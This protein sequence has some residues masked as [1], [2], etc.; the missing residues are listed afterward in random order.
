[1]SLD[2]KQS[3]FAIWASLSAPLIISAWIPGFSPEEYK[4]LTNKEIIA[5]NQDS[6][7]LQCTL[8]SQDGTW[9]VLTKDLANGDRL[10]TVINR[11]STTATQSVSFERIGI[12]SASS[13]HVKD[14]WTGASSLGK[15]EVIAKN[16]P[17]HGTAVFRISAV[18]GSL[19]S[20]AT[21]MIFN[22]YS[23]TTLTSSKKGLKWANATA[24]DGQAWQTQADNTLRP[25]SDT[26]QCLQ[27]SGRG[28][29]DLV[30]CNGKS[31]Q[32][33]DYLYSG[34]LRSQSSKKCL[35]E[36]EHEKVTTSKCLYE[37]NSQVFGL[38]SGIEIIGS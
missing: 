21:G 1:M 25:L 16:V 7:A 36:T 30:S 34:N 38:P 37:A 17:S 29:I 28:D 22:T 31:S 13:V 2:E 9:D 33:W 19:N 8:V 12:P 26:T 5:V 4:Y 6:L 18:A 32:K 14:L 20:V 10:L 15:N 3:H 24:V 11:G 27:D 23:L 35:T